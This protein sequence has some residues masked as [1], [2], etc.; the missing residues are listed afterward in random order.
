MLR[1][2]VT[3]L[4]L[5]ITVIHAQ[6]TMTAQEIVEFKKNVKSVAAKTK[7]ISSD[8][9]QYKHMEFLSNDIKT[10]GK[11]QFKV[12]NLVKWS[13]TKPFLYSVIFKEG[14]LL[15]NDE[16]KKSDVNIGSNKLFKKLNQL[17]VKSISGDMFDNTE[18]TM[19]FVKTTNNYVVTFDSKDA[20]LKKYIKQFVLHF[21]KQNY[22]VIEV[23]MV[24]PSDDYTQI[25][26]KNRK[27]NQTIKDEVF[28]N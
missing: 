3:F 20:E 16:G 27:E 14:K 5:G 1:V 11:M 18:F 25:V 22:A 26:F 10:S 9:D 4:F 17:I 23:K 28:S 21:N 8:F 19:N 2:I 12:P 24:E 15:I 6:K 7:T 13:Y